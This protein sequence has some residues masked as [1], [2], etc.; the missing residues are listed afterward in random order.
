MAIVEL[1]HVEPGGEVRIATPGEHRRAVFR[2]Q[3]PE[4]LR[5]ARQRLGSSLDVELRPGEAPAVIGSGV[6]GYEVEHQSQ[7]AATQS[8]A[9]SQQSLAAAEVGVRGV[10]RDSEGRA[11]DVLVLEVRQL[12]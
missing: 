8:V 2:V 7:S 10:G 11:G 1:D 6:I 5:V 12:L 3:L 4:A 9:E